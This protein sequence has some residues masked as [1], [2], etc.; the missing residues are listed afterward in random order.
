MMLN[1]SSLSGKPGGHNSVQYRSAVRAH[2][3]TVND[4][5]FKCKKGLRKVVIKGSV[6]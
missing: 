5:F 3:V 1:S 2:S 6:T 4:T